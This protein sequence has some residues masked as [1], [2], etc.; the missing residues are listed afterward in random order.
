MKRLLMLVLSIA[1][2][3]AF[4]SVPAFATQPG[5]TV[6]PNGYPS[7]DH[8]NLNILGKKDGF[9]CE[10]QVDELGNPVYG[11]VVFVP[12]NGNNI[13][14]QMQSGKGNK[15]A[16][17]PTLQAIDPCSASIDGDA[18]IIQIPKN[19]LGY[20]VYARALGKPT[21]SPTMLITPKLIAVEDESGNDL[22]YLGLV[23]STGFQTP[24]SAFSRKKGQ[25]T[26]RDITGLFE[27]SGSVCYFSST[28]CTTG[29]TAATL[30]CTPG[31]TAGTYTSCVPK[32][33]LC[34]A[35]TVEVAAFCSSYTDEW[36]FN[37]GDFVTYLWDMENEGVKNLQV[38]F[39][40]N[41]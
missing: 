36:V 39:Y 33:D 22:V 10:E 31:L 18:A 41:Y 29:C 40:P 32:V 8:Y 11:N 3:A 7:G 15:A 35:G 5:Q 25:S 37:I 9:T 34:L 23:T 28:Y 17:I 26:A 30:C 1:V 6:N 4:T 13:Q 2:V 21:N 16:A 27:W 12:L 24:Y 38:R 19:D 20:R 14:I